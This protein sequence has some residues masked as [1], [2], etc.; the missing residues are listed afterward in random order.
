MYCNQPLKG[1]KVVDLTGYGAGP[2]AGKILGDWGADVIKVES[3]AGDP[4]RPSGIALGL[5]AD[6][7]QNPHFEQK[8]ANKRGITLDLKTPEGQEIMDKLLKEANIFISNFRLKALVKLGLDYETVSKKFPHLIWGHLCGFGHEGPAADNPGFDTVS[9]YARSGM[10]I[11]FCEGGTEGGAYPL[12]PPFGLGDTVVGLQFASGVAISLYQ[13]AKTGKGEKVVVSLYGSAM[14][15]EAWVMQEVYHGGKYPKTRFYPDSPMRNTF[16]CKDGTWFMLSV[17]VYDR[18]YP[19]ICKII[20]RED[21]I[22]DERFN[23]EKKIRSDKKLSNEFLKILDAAFAT[24]DWP[25]WDKILRENDLAHDR[26]NHMIDAL[27][28]E[29]AKANN[30]MY[31]YKNRDGSDDLAITTPIRFGGYY[32]YPHKTCPLLGEHSTEILESLGYTDEQIAGFI[33]KGVVTQHK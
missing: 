30:N 3:L 25:E 1:I 19:V 15:S 9:Y 16:R 4:S 32:T 28:D 33:S 31:F 27:N 5:R 17:I 26:I 21:L 2:I 11:D 12:T 18:Y 6:E 8:D 23:N 29:Q 24:K 10:M 22:T 14:Y 20:G 13:Q 7:E